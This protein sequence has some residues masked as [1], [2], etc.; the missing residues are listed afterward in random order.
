MKYIDSSKRN[1]VWA[2][3][4]QEEN[5]WFNSASFALKA[6]TNPYTHTIAY[7]LRGILEAGLYL[8][9]E[10]YIKSVDT[11]AG[12]FIDSLDKNEM[13]AGTYDRRWTGDKSFSCLTGNAQIAIV[14]FK[15]Y[16][17]TGNIKY[18]DI[19]KRINNFLKSKQELRLKTRCVHGAIA[20]SFPIRGKYI[21]YAYPNWASKF[22]IDSLVIEEEIEKAGV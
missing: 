21:H 22:F 19:A 12:N 2:L 9:E 6:H 11:A 3:K 17:K 4:Q 8:D 5:G 10:K 16:G 20:G 1:I 7:T 15:L 14:L 18:L 13:V